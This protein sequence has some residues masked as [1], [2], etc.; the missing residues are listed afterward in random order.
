MRVWSISTFGSFGL[1]LCSKHTLL[2]VAFSIN[3]SS[4]K[5][6]NKLRQLNISEYIWCICFLLQFHFW[7]GLR[8]EVQ[9]I[10]MGSGSSG[11]CLFRAYK[12]MIINLVW[13]FISHFFG[14]NLGQ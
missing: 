10:L 2:C 4:V 9:V 6:R 7:I 12:L 1:K 8:T 3:P 13:I 14:D 11:F 5:A